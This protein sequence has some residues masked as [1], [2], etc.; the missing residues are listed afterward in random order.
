LEREAR[1]AAGRSKDL[2]F[3]LEKAAAFEHG[4][5]D[6]DPSTVLRCC[7]FAYAAPAVRDDS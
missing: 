2:F 3:S 7:G 1:N 4:K 6:G 5:H